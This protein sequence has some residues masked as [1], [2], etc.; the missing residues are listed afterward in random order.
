MRNAADTRAQAATAN[1]IAA[2]IPTLLV[3]PRRDNRTGCT[4]YR[5]Q[6][7]PGSTRNASIPERRATGT[8]GG[9]QPAHIPGA[10]RGEYITAYCFGDAIYIAGT[11]KLPPLQVLWQ[12]LEQEEQAV[13]RDAVRLL[14]CAEGMIELGRDAERIMLTDH[15]ITIQ[16]EGQTLSRAARAELVQL[17]ADI[18]HLKDDTNAE[19]II[20]QL[21]R[22]LADIG[23][24]PRKVRGKAAQRGAQ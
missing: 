11:I 1:T 13:A 18:Q 20:K 24:T 10:I 21:P 17:R 5:H 15:A 9:L 14:D 2:G 16:A 22:R 19:Q 4:D 8:D 6:H 3:Q 23:C 12:E 7:K